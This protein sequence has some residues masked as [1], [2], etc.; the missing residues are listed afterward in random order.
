MAEFEAKVYKLTIEEHPNADAIELARVGDYVSIVKKGQFKTGDLGVYIPEASVLPEWLITELGLEGRLAGKQK[1]RV[2]AVR[3][4]GIFSQGLVYPVETKVG[5]YKAYGEIISQ[6][7]TH[8]IRIPS[9]S[10]GRRV[11]E[12]DDVTDLLGLIKYEPKI[13]TC[14]DGEVFN[15][16]GYTLKYDIENIKKYPYVLQEPTEVVVMT[17]KIHGTW[18]CFGFHPAID[19]PIVTS[20]GLSERGLAFKH[21]EA[22]EKNLYLRAY[23]A[24]ITADGTVIDRTRKVIQE[25]FEFDNDLTPFYILGEVYGCG[26]QDLH[27]GSSVPLFRVFDVYLGEPGTG[28]YLDVYEKEQLC[29]ALEIPTVPIMYLGPFYKS[30]MEN[31]TNGGETISGKDSNMR[32]GIVITPIHERRDTELGRVILKSVSEAY[33]LRKGKPT[34]YN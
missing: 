2:K 24:E 1:N 29:E 27:Y 34:E 28:R 8:V 21:N 20:K 23:Y 11:E 33:I 14:M 22:N 30:V 10:S 9:E 4:R 12:G 26:V 5:Q 6:F 13:P 31:C 16:F 18:C 25:M 7:N 32:E 15:A 17:E 19:V 3:L